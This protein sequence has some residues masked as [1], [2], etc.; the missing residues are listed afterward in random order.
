M[1]SIVYCVDNE[2]S[3]EHH[4][5]ELY[6]AVCCFC[7]SI[8]LSLSL[9]LSIHITGIMFLFENLVNFDGIKVLDG[10][11]ICANLDGKTT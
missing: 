5:I 4:V 11:P 3:F 1:T 7:F 10:N 9:C 8:S 6:V 2:E